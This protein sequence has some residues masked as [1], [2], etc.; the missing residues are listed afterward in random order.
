[1]I[2]GIRKTPHACHYARMISS[3]S[4][5]KSSY[6]ALYNSANYRSKSEIARK[7]MLFDYNLYLEICKRKVSTSDVDNT[8][9]ER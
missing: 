6:I 5:I 7:L 9:K 4:N 2:K 8:A 3:H 1:M